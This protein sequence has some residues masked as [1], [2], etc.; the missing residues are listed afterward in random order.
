MKKKMSFSDSHAELKVNS[1]H[2]VFIPKVFV[3][4]YEKYILWPDDSKI[5]ETL[6]DLDN[7]EN[8]FYWDSWIY[9]TDNCKLTSDTGKQF[10]LYQ[11]DGDLWA[12]P[13]DEVDLIN[14][15]EM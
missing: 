4:A 10:I 8:E 1:A 13:A 7:P 5:E 12:V 9:L 14:W 2:G 6:A 11:L 15:E 3:E